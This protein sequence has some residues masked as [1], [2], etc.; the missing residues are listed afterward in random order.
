MST[1]INSDAFRLI[2]VDTEKLTVA[3]LEK[4]KLDELDARLCTG[5]LD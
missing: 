5:L 3:R 1:I 4:I 2:D